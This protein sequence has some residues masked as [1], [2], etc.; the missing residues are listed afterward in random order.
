M[1]NEP[2]SGAQSID[3]AWLPF[4]TKRQTLEAA[5]L[6]ASSQPARTEAH[7]Q[8]HALH[9]ESLHTGPPYDSGQCS[10]C[11]VFEL[12]N[13]TRL[14]FSVATVKAWATQSM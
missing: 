2:L 5:V 10:P 12:I 7:R 4:K 13:Q 1:S 6:R 14:G 11:K 9:V 8:R 3:P